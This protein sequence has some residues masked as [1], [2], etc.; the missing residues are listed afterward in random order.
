MGKRKY[1]ISMQTPLGV[2]YGTMSVTWAGRMLNGM[3]DILNHIEP[4]SGT[5][6]E[7]GDCRIHGRMITLVRNIEYT[8]VGK[9]SPEFIQLTMRGERNTF[10]LHGCRIPEK[11]EK[12]NGSSVHREARYCEQREQ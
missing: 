3:L 9:I 7:N 4:F 11:E 1:Q 6:E 10:E 2:R 5:I 8:A 12:E